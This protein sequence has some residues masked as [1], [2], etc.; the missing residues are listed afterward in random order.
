MMAKTS[1]NMMKKKVSTLLAVTR[2]TPYNIV[3]SN[4]PWDVLKPFLS[5]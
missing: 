1:R 2:F 3:L 5:T 4:F